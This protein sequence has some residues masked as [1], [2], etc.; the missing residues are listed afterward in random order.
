MPRIA[1]VGFAR[2][3]TRTSKITKTLIDLSEKHVAMVRKFNV[4]LTVRLLGHKVD[5]FVDCWDIDSAMVDTVPVHKA[6]ARDRRMAVCLDIV[7]DK[8][9]KRRRMG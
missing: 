7:L 5:T 2:R 3:R 1:P 8:G 6:V 9:L 4:Q